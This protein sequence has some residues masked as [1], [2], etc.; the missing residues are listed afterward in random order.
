MNLPDAT[1][2]AK[3]AG[4]PPRETGPLSAV[5]VTGGGAD[6][7]HAYDVWLPVC[8][9]SPDHFFAGSSH[10]GKWWTR[11][12]GGQSRLR[13]RRGWRV[14]FLDTPVAGV[15]L[16]EPQVFGDA[17]GFFIETWQQHKFAAAG[18]DASFVQ[19]NHSRSSR[20]TLR[21][22][23]LQV[24]QTQGKLVRV[25]SGAVFDAVVDLRRSSPTFGR[26]W[27]GGAS[28]RTTIT[29]CCGCPRAWLTASW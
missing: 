20:W 18:I 19:D 2:C 17:R 3:G 5:T 21:G 29:G 10:R 11:L 8:E 15:V 13:S 23:H 25:T 1:P 9:R 22:L 7:R 14:K 6:Q 24:R 28:P 12:G 27:S 26:T 4:L 16:I